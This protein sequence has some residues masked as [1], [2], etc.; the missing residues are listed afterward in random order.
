MKK[1]F[2]RF[3]GVNKYV[4]LGPCVSLNFC[5]RFCV[6]V[7]EKVSALLVH[8]SLFFNSSQ[9]H[10]LKIKCHV[11]SLFLI[12]L[13]GLN[14]IFVLRYMETIRNTFVSCYYNKTI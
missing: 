11:I 14:D 7:S 4:K 9:P 8:S 6:W 1:R 2:E 3:I 5:V 13:N 12:L 10:Y